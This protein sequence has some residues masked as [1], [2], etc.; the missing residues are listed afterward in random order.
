MA[1]KSL[2]SESLLAESLPARSSAR[3]ANGGDPAAI[4]WQW[5]RSFVAVIEGGS[6]TAAARLLHTT[7]P[8]I[9]RHIRALEKRLGETLFERQPGGLVA[10]ARATELYE[11]SAAVEQAVTGL[12][13]SL[14]NELPELSGTVRVTASIGFAVELLP[15]LLASL[16]GKHAHLQVNLM[17]DDDVRNLIRREADVAVRLAPPAQAEI[18]AT[19]IG[20]LEIGL[21]A[22]RAYLDR[23]GRPRRLAQ[24][25]THAFVG[26]DNATAMVAAAAALGA[27][28]DARQVRLHSQ[29]Y[30]AQLAA[31]KAGIGI[32]AVQ[33]WLADRC[34]ELVR[35]LPSTSVA[36]LPVWV[37]THDDFHR[38]RRI[39]VVFEH[40]VSELRQRFARF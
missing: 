18:V 32:G 34:P 15:E 25:G 36:R 19:R 4:D 6:L 31:V 11:R 3:S 10:T 26:F 16:L 29:N 37:A 8:T 24:L 21:Y 27:V 14:G 40:L 28:V 35:V 17:A 9:G 30:L 12:T 2:L 23:K 7:Q 33:T 1:S 38:S 13:A 20:D 5:L 39:R 22:S